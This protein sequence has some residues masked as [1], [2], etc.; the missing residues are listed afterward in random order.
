MKHTYTHLLPMIAFLLLH[1][2]FTQAQT[3]DSPGA[4]R[5]LKHPAALPIEA[6]ALRHALP[7][8]GKEPTAQLPQLPLPTKPHLSQAVNLGA[9]GSQAH[10]SGPVREQWVA[11]YTTPDNSY[12]VATSTAVDA[13]GNVYVTGYS[14]QDASNAV[15]YDYLT[16]KYSAEG[17]KQWEGRYN[18]SANG[19]DVAKAI[20]VDSAGNVYVTGSSYNGTSY[21]YATL[22][23]SA[24]GQQLWEARYNGP[25]DN[26][27]LAVSLAV[28]AAGNLLVT[29]ASYNGPTTSYD[30]VTVK[31]SSVGAQLWT[32]RYNGSGNSDELPTTLALDGSGN[33]YVT[34]NAYAGNQGDY[35]TLKYS[36]TGQP[37]W[38]ARY[39][40]PASGYDLARDLAVDAAGNVAV[41]GTS[42]NGSSYDYATVRYSTSGQ[43]LW[44]TRYN[45]GGNSYDE[46]TGVALDAAGNVA[47]TG[48]ANTGNNNWNYVTIFYAS[49]NGQRVWL[50][51]YNGPDNGYD[52]AKD[53]AVDAN[54]SVAV[55]GRSYNSS[56]ESDYVTLK[57]SNVGQQLWEA[58]YNGPARGDDEATALAVDAAG[59]VLVTGTSFAGSRNFDY[60]TLKYAAT[61]GEQM[62]VS[63]F[64]GTQT[65]SPATQAKDMAVDPVGNVVVTGLTP[66]GSGS[67]SYATVKYAAT[68]QKLWEARYSFGFISADLLAVEV[69]AAGNVYIAG[70]FNNEYTTIKYDGASGR[71][72]WVRRYFPGVINRGNRV[73]DLVVDAAGNA[74]VTGASVMGIT[75]GFDYATIKY[76]PSGEQLWAM[77]YVSARND[78]PSSLTLDAAG[79][80]FVTG[81]SYSEQFNRIESTT[82]KYSPSGQV[83][84]VAR[85]DDPVREDN[86][87]AITVDAVGNVYVT[88]TS[89]LKYSSSGTLLWTAQYFSNGT[90]IAVDAAG[91]VLVT[92]TGYLNGNASQGV[93]VTAKCDGA[94]GQRLWQ[95]FSGAGN[96]TDQ[97]VDMAIDSAGD[98]YVTGVSVNG[99]SN[100]NTIKYAGTSGHVLWETRDNTPSIDNNRPVRVVVD[101]AGS[102]VVAGTT[103]ASP[104]DPDYLII[105]YTQASSTAST[106]VLTTRATLTALG[107][108]QQEL[109]VYPNPAAGQAS[110][111]FRPMLDG[112]AQVAVYNQ[113]GQ[114][115]ASLYE[116]AVRKGQHYELPL[117]SHKLAPGLYICSLLVGGQRETVRVLVTH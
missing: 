49:A 92:G 48:F 100:Y 110:V 85:Y 98:A 73:T 113:L 21:D 39:N 108:M 55:A 8:T 95:V 57:Y 111:S 1:N 114:Q 79:N 91:N 88:G 13:A 15:S 41:T 12:D 104:T 7:S 64:T 25:A 11:R 53:I 37:Q 112:P 68:G 94:T 69:D 18:G 97:A 82:I 106:A 83:Q 31:Y 19:D 93:W 81:I 76:S 74:Y 58:R 20:A 34:G 2:S 115:V 78:I 43:Q 40:G 61:T 72:L 22:K 33:V 56:G 102:V 109:A 90:A 117:H 54:G 101:A 38:E 103:L 60:A 4:S 105:K 30:Y 24:H 99:T 52:E 66:V 87:T 116:G 51:E 28:D 46:A 63:I 23:Y 80:V 77:R 89:T 5:L 71:Q 65:S 84:W 26:D 62:W 27:D 14:F 6:S 44:A 32:A 50:R 16:I 75:T 36:T 10:T 96:T 70:S 29:G 67:N 59:N 9:R 17:V 45:G 35:L 3:I 42:D 107:N 86:P 47:V